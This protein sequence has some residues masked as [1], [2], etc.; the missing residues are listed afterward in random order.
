[1]TKS[2]LSQLFN[3]EHSADTIK[4]I[5]VAAIKYKEKQGFQLSRGDLTV[6]DKLESATPKKIVVHPSVVM[7]TCRTQALSIR[8]G[9]GSLDNVLSLIGRELSS[10][11]TT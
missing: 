11:L 4:L 2:H 3:P 6:L 9:F 7:N 5:A 8:Y 1:M 10:V